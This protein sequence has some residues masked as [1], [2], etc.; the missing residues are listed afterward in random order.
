MPLTV[1][2]L[3]VKA[4][5]DMWGLT[6]LL[7]V[8]KHVSEIVL[9]TKED[10]WLS[11]RRCGDQAADV[12]PLHWI[13]ATGN[14]SQIRTKTTSNTCV[15]FTKLCVYLCVGNEH[16]A[17][18]SQHPR[19]PEAPLQPGGWYLVLCRRPVHRREWIGLDFIFS[20]LLYWLYCFYDCCAH[21]A[22]CC[23]CLESKSPCSFSE[24]EGFSLA[25]ELVYQT[26]STD[27]HL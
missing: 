1:D 16:S 5:A 23:L 19:Q 14:V 17:P 18:S 24:T 15:S 13:M 4:A 12:H 7:L 10:C 3:T 6:K 27:R 21:V 11:K 20:F 2:P 9:Q 22:C 26:G 8:N 25:D